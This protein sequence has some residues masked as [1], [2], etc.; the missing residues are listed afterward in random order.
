M[1]ENH[2]TTTLPTSEDEVN[3]LPINN[4]IGVTAAREVLVNYKPVVTKLGWE[5]LQHF[6]VRGQNFNRRVAIMAVL[7]VLLV[8]VLFYIKLHRGSKATVEGDMRKSLF[9]S[10]PKSP[11]QNGRPSSMVFKEAHTVI[12]AHIIAEAISTLHGLD[13]RWSGSITPTEMQYV[14]QYVLAK[15]PE[16]SNALVEGGEK[17]DLYNLC[18]KEEPS[19][20]LIDDKRKI[21]PELRFYPYHYAP[22]A[23]D[24]YG[25]DQL[26]IYFTLGKPFKP[27]DQLMGV[28]PAASAHALPFFYRKLMTDSSSPILDFYPDDFELDMDG[29]RFA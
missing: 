10:N 17:T 18:I 15:Y 2:H 3:I 14:E 20:L 5:I 29:K 13:L 1:P 24:F 21:N 7:F 26:E 12:P 9:A 19:N 22:F 8:L 6:F 27:F 25:L 11:T 28:L 16:Y 4:A 23:S